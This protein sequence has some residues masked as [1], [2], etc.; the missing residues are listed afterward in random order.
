M[1]GML[2]NIKM[3]NYQYTYIVMCLILIGIW[4][5]FFLRRKDIRKEILSI[6]LIFGLAAPLAAYVYIQDWWRPLTI[7]G[8]SIGIEDF[9]FGF[10]I[11]GIASI[12]YTY[13]FNKKV[14][15]KKNKIKKQKRNINLLTLLILLMGIF[16]I[17]FFVFNLNSF[18][19]TILAFG[20]PTLIIYI[21]RRDLIKDSIISGIS[22][23]IIAIIIY[24]L[25]NIITPGFFDEFWLFQNIG[26]IMLFGMPLEEIIWFLLAGVFIGPLY[27]YWQEGKL[28]NIKK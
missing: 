25:L 3:V 9:I 18:I 1:L 27:E 6:S 14:K 24:Q 11:G 28:I 23:L 17:G 15:I 5:Y 26:R 22:T 4:L 7:T 16:F 8:T 19:S 12:I 2:V 21:K 20:I 10:A 13:L